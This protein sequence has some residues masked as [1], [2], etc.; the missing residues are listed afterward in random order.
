M[1]ALSREAARQLDREDPLGE[2]RD[3]FQL[4]DGIVYLDGNSLGALPKATLER[5]RALL[6]DEWG[7]SLIRSWNCHDWIGAPRRVGAKLAPLLGAG[8]DEVLVA[9]STSVN[10]FKLLVAAARRSDRRVLLSEAGNFHT[11]LHIAAGVA[12]L[13]GPDLEIVPLAEIADR[14]DERVNLVLLTHVHYKTA[15]RFDLGALTAQAKSVGASLVWDLSHSAGAV[16]LALNAAGVELA[17][18]CGYK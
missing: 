10:L 7:E 11:D 14:I 12:D 1:S 13:M 16:P 5:Q 9:D 2:F 4:P 3:R 18:G 17:V 6:V 8:A 15:E